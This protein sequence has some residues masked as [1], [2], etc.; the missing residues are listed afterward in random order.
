[1][2]IEDFLKNLFVTR[3]A[4]QNCKFRTTCFVFL[5]YVFLQGLGGHGSPQL[6]HFCC[7][8]QL[9]LFIAHLKEITCCFAMFLLPTMSC[10]YKFFSQPSFLITCT[11]N[12]T[13]LIL[14]VIIHFVVPILLVVLIYYTCG[15]ISVYRSEDIFVTSNH[16]FE[17]IVHYSLLFKI[18]DI[19]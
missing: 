4:I 18:S 7:F 5:R 15:I 12:F 19:T 16:F 8:T 6:S 13:C 11:N 2:F 3:A 17:D 9:Y 14:I 10:G 1:M